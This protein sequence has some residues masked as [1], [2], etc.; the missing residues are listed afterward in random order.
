M[1]SKKSNEQNG[2]KDISQ[3]GYKEV[4]ESQKETMKFG[5]LGD[6]NI[7]PNVSTSS[8]MAGAQR[9]GI[10]ANE[11][12]EKDAKEMPESIPNERNTNSENQ[13]QATKQLID[14]LTTTLRRELGNWVEEQHNKSLTPSQ[15]AK[16]DFAKDVAKT[17]LNRLAKKRLDRSMVMLSSHEEESIR[18]SAFSNIFGAGLWEKFLNDPTL[19]DVHINGYDSVWQVDRNGNKWQTEPVASSNEELI[20]QIRLAGSQLG[21]SSRRFDYNTPILNMRLLGGAR[22]HAIMNV[23]TV[24]MVTIRFHNAEL[25]NL[26]QLK[27]QGMF[28]EAIASFLR[29]AIKGRFNIVICGG[30]GVGK[31]TLCRAIL[32]EVPPNERIVTVEDE[33][34]LGLENY[35][36][37][38]PDIG[39]LEARPPNLEGIGGITLESLLRECLRM[40]AD[41]I[42]VGEVRGPEVLGMLL[43]M[44]S[45]QKGS[46][47][48]I[49]ANSTKEAFE[50]LAMY[51]S[52]TAQQYSQSFTYRL[53]G[54]AVDFVIHLDHISGRRR[55]TSI[56][57][58]IDATS[59]RVQSNEIWKPGRDGRAVISGEPFRVDP[60][61]KNLI[62]NGFDS[63]IMKVDRDLWEQ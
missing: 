13:T 6:D 27:A 12:G 54:S 61:L 59:D 28:D 29:A 58:V 35:I 14:E 11:T 37:N 30:M 62:N 21:R 47:C 43:A 42:V 60:T 56:R 3:N 44:T 16:E 15:E 9:N 50:R 23:S 20:H 5:N 31:T 46:I 25:A 4:D 41:R 63:E 2:E 7:D 1:I 33:L 36:E 38:H 53:V 39:V 45:G 34:E 52:M 57:E 17:W 49:H 22:M 24:P 40:H 55:I 10:Q 26:S 19:S 18:A 51:A 48:T 8:Q 32:N